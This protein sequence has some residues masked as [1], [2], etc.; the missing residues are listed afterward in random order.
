MTESLS[1]IKEFQRCGNRCIC[2]S[3]SLDKFMTHCPSHDDRFPSLSVKEH[4]SGGKPLLNC[5][6]G[7]DYELISNAFELLGVYDDQH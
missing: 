4:S 1:K 3:Y 7:C 5:F 2:S 6:A